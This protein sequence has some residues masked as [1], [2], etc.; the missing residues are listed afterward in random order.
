VHEFSGEFTP[1]TKQKQFDKPR[2]KMRFPNS[3]VPSKDFS[4]IRQPTFAA[5]LLAFSLTPQH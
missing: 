5:S 4:K 3:S 1:K 2:E